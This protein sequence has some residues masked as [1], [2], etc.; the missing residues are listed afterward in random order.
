M[1]VNYKGFEI[2]VEREKA[3][4]GWDST[5]YQVMEIETG[6]F[7]VDSFSDS[8]DT[9]REWVKDLKKV[10]DGYL[11]NPEEWEDNY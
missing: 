6:F 11:E 4:G 3:L 2:N 8:T 9:I 10:V 1:K 7:L 5:Y